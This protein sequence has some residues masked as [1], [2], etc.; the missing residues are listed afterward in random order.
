MT[1]QVPESIVYPAISVAMATYNGEKYLE[2]QLD[3][4]L[5]QTLKPSEII[6][7]DDQSTDGTREIL[8]RYQQKGLLPLLI[9]ISL[10]LIRMISGFQVRFRLQQIFC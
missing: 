3:S 6:V 5:S 2:E 1:K 7:C 8:D 4:I 9:I 10:C